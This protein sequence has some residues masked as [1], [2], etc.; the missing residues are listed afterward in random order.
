MHLQFLGRIPTMVQ[1]NVPK[2]SAENLRILKGGRIE[3]IDNKTGILSVALAGANKEIDLE[4][5]YEYSINTEATSLQLPF[6]ELLN[7]KQE[8]VIQIWTKPGVVISTKNNQW[9]EHPLEAVAKIIRL[10]NA[11]FRS[12]KPSSYLDIDL[13][14]GL[15]VVP[16]V[17]KILA[18]AKLD[19]TQIAYRVSYS[20]KTQPTKFLIF[21]CLLIFKMPNSPSI[22]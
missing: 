14:S 12:E 6:L 10:P 7:S 16:V 4:F 18:R 9:K 17:E 1:F 19:R 15:G 2:E 5:D 21:L 22:I 13:S 3:G 8:T 20:Y 11:S